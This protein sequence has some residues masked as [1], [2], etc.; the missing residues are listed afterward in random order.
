[1]RF[2]IRR[3][4]ER[5]PGRQR[6]LERTKLAALRVGRDAS[7]LRDDQQARR[8]VE[9]PHR[10][11]GAEN[12]EPACGGVRRRKKHRAQ[13]TNLLRTLNQALRSFQRAWRALEA[14]QVD[15]IEMLT[16]YHLEPPFVV[17]RPMTFD[18]RE[19]LPV[20]Q[21]A[22]GAALAVADGGAIEQREHHSEERDA[23]I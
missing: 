9:D 20:L 19:A 3:A 6:A 23:L 5:R 16:R 14:E 7:C 8:H 11:G 4:E 13:D 2:A 1:M 15:A 10:Q 17:L 18:S 21:F 12:V 22:H